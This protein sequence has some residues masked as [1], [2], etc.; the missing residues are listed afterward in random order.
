MI[1]FSYGFD[2]PIS[3]TKNEEYWWRIRSEMKGY[4]TLIENSPFGV[5][6]LRSLHLQWINLEDYRVEYEFDRIN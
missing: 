1:R 4:K 5:D 2:F 6:A 3:L